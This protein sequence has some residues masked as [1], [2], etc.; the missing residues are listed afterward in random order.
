MS[1][2]MT[3]IRDIYGGSYLEHYGVLGMK[4]GVRKDRA[5][6]IKKSYSKLRDL[7]IRSAKRKSRSESYQAR[8]V[9]KTQRALS[10]IARGKVERGARIG[11]RGAR[12]SRKSYRLARSSARLQRRASS[13]VKSMNKYLGETKMSELTPN[14]IMLGKKYLADLIDDRKY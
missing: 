7:D 2:M 1:Q 12:L 10:A 11:R 4:W 6:A 5:K 8:G 9:A 13:W 14:Q 3:F